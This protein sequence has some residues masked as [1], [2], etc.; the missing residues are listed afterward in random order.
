MDFGEALKSLK[1]GRKV[2]RIGWNAHHFLGLQEVDSGSVNT[3]PYIYLVVGDDAQ[4]LQGKRV[5][6]V[7]SQ[8]DLL[9]EDWDEKVEMEK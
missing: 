6:W 3:M 9:A 1:A 4:D 2:A 7:A 5:P 8:R